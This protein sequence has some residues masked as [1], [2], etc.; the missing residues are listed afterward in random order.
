MN[1]KDALRS[2]ILEELDKALTNAPLDEIVAVFWKPPEAERVA[3]SSCRET[4]T[5]P[6]RYHLFCL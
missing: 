3:L 5:V 4:L 6:A 1:Y 2:A